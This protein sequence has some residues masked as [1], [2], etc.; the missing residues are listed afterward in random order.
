MCPWLFF[1]SPNTLNL[2]STK[3]NL[4]LD[5]SVKGDGRRWVRELLFFKQTH[6]PTKQLQTVRYI[7]VLAF[8]RSVPAISLRAVIGLNE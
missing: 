1:F 4:L 2:D 7:S 6:T 5:S 8:T 3:I